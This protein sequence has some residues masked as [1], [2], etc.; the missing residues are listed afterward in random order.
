MR[1]AFLLFFSVCLIF[2]WFDAFL[3]NPLGTA[4]PFL[5]CFLLQPFAIVHF[6]FDNHIDAFYWL[7]QVAIEYQVFS[8][9]IGQGMVGFRTWYSWTTKRTKYHPRHWGLVV[10]PRLFQRSKYFFTAET[11]RNFVAGRR[12]ARF[13]SCRLSCADPGAKDWQRWPRSSSWGFSSQNTNSQTNSRGKD[14]EFLPAEEAALLPLV[15]M[16]ASILSG[17]RSTWTDAQAFGKLLKV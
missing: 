1:V 8:W 11:C 13:P 7:L 3:F 12:Q 2:F 10:F 15:A 4:G 5:E 9:G 16:R 14:K 6:E 17:A